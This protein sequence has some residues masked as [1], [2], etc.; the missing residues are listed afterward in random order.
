MIPS[1]TPLISSSTRCDRCL[2]CK[3]ARTPVTSSSALL[4]PPQVIDEH[5]LDR[6]VVGAQHVAHAVSANQMANLFREVLGVVSGAFQRLRHEQHVK[7]FLALDP[8]VIFQV[9]QE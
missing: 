3:K 6:L 2:L 9:P 8:I 1:G 7:A 5:L 4:A